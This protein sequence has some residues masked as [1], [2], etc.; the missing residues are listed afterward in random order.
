MLTACG[1][2]KFRVGT[3]RTAHGTA[4]GEREDAREAARLAKDVEDTGRGLRRWACAIGTYKVLSTRG[5]RGRA[6]SARRALVIRGCMR[7]E[8]VGNGLAGFADA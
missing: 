4:E 6:E 5:G 3:E 8:R 2:C 1:E 7:T